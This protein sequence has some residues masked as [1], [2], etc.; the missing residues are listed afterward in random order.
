MCGFVLVHE[1]SSW[2]L[3]ASSGILTFDYIYCTVGKGSLLCH[4][5]ASSPVVDETFFGRVNFWHSQTMLHSLLSSF[6]RISLSLS[7]AAQI[8][9]V[10]I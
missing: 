6:S 5:A 9:H 2:E 1:S 4:T 3:C 7:S 8:L 10:T